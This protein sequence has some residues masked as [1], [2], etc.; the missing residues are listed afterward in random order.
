MKKYEVSTNGKR[1]ATFRNQREADAFVS[2]CERQ[3]R[4]EVSMGYG[5]PNG[6]PV[7]TISKIA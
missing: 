6:L 7:Y 3:D 5:F 2:N 1:I 4:Y